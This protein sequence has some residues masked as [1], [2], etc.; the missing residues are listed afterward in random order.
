[1]KKKIKN[2]IET[3]RNYDETTKL[4]IMLLISVCTIVIGLSA[5][6]LQKYIGVVLI[7]G[8]LILVA[9]WDNITALF[10]KKKNPM[11]SCGDCC[12]GCDAVYPFVLTTVYDALKVVAPILHL[13]I[14]PTE[15]QIQ[16]ISPPRADGL[17]HWAFRVM[18]R[19]GE[20][21]ISDEDVLSCFRQTLQDSFASHGESFFCTGIQDLYA[22]Q[23]KQDDYSITFFIMPYCPSCTASYIDR[24]LTREQIRRE[25]QTSKREEHIYDDQI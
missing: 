15:R 11:G 24:M 9:L 16:S 8:S 20:E 21:A 4:F 10:Q 1:M 18:K 25:R 12:I 2:M 6:F 7:S 13:S 19:N 14:P 5:Y 22:E 23:I 17:P 3:Y